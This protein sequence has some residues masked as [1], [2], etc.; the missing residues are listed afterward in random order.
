M[1]KIALHILLAVLCSLSLVGCEKDPAGHDGEGAVSFEVAVPRS[2]AAVDESVYPWTDCAIRIYKY[3]AAPSDGEE[4][5]RELIRRYNSV[6]EMPASMWL[7]AGDYVITVELGAKEEATFDRP[8]YRGEKDFAIVGGRTVQV[9]VECRIANT[10]VEVDYDATVTD[11]FTEELWTDVVL[12]ETYNSQAVGNGEVPVLRYTESRRGYFILP[13]GL[14]AFSWRFRGVGQKKDREEIVQIDKTKH[15][16]T[17][18]GMLYKL[19][20]RYSPDL[21]GKLVFSIVVENTWNEYSDPVVFAPDPQISGDGFDIEER[22]EFASGTIGY[23][24]ASISDLSSVKLRCGGREWP[25]ALSSE[26]QTAGVAVMMTSAS[27]MLLSL[28]PEFFAQLPG[29]DLDLTLYAQD[30]DGRESEKV[31]KVRTQ[32]VFDLTTTDA[33]NDRGELKAYVFDPS[34]AD[35]KIRYRAAGAAEWREAAAASTAQSGV[36]AASVSVSPNTSYECQL[37]FGQTAVNGASEQRIDVAEPQIPGAGFE[38]WF[39]YKDK[40]LV[41]APSEASWWWDSGNHG[42][43]TLGV[44]VTQSVAD[45]RPGSTGTKA[46]CL[47]SQFVGLISV[48]KFA[49]GNIFFGKYGGTNGTNGVIGFGNPFSFT[50]RPR[51]LTFWYKGTV[52]TIDRIDGDNAPVSKGDTDVAQ[53][54][55]CLCKMGGPH[56][57]DTRDQTTFFDPSSKTV[58]YCTGAL[59]KSSKNDATDGKIIAWAEWTN[60]KT[61][62]EWTQYTLD[63]KYNDEYEGEVPD[64]L[65]LTASASKYGDYFA[66]STGSVM[67]LDDFELV[68]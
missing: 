45:P 67:Y 29:G 5:G 61:V 51:Q 48:G 1:K 50:Y 18:P 65:M 8:F 52:G 54:Y 9:A 36:Y 27:D 30:E 16:S 42:S 63:L 31:A 56:V 3:A 58:S 21:G 37:C 38:D 57:I 11:L 15:I 46:A 35:V 2:R 66:G 10:I 53:I 43:S 34:A 23:H 47:Q 32:G 59:D 39:T 7:A 62:G 40:V 44:N 68:Y 49:A 6:G 13:E 4:R 55:I 20:F 24:I 60:T 64:Y 33:W 12:A 17:D 25:V 19:R 28:A 26:G 14:E 41:P 22:R